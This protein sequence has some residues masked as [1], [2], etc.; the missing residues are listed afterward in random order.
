MAEAEQQAS[1]LLRGAADKLQRQLGDDLPI[2]TEICH[3]VVIPTLAEATNDAV[4]LVL[5]H[6]RTRRRARGPVRSVTEGVL[7]HAHAPVLVVPDDW[8]AHAARGDCAVTVGLPASTAAH[9]IIRAALDEA[10]RRDTRL[11]VVHAIDPGSSTEADTHDPAGA[12]QLRNL[13]LQQ[14]LAQLA[15]EQP[16]V[17]V[18]VLVVAESPATALIRAAAT[19]ALVV[20]GRRHSPTG[21]AM[22]VGHVVHDLLARSPLPL[23][24]VDPQ[25]RD[26]EATASGPATREDVRQA[27]P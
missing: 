16:E 19:S 9:G 12:A 13:R 20:V 2:T 24:V 25:K 10:E 14:A 3:G 4:L 23:L 5:E 7:A 17:P 18:E 27:Y 22:H 21:S 26:N 15:F 8:R 1:R 6:R 11:L